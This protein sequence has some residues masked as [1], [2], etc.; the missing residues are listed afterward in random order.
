MDFTIEQRFAAP[1]DAVLALYSSASFYAELTDLPKISRP[2]VLSREVDGTEVALHVRYLFAADL[3]AAALALIDPKKLS[4]VD[5]TTFDLAARTA[6]T[7]LVPD[8]YRDRMTASATTTYDPTDGGTIRRVR[9]ECKVR[10][11]LVGGQ[12]EKAIVS[13]LEEH[14]VDEQKVATR[15]LGG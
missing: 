1:P 8:H 15:L 10:M 5:H 14:F 12:V 11:P 4:W 6:T 7:V 3:P 9:G 13:G 2:E